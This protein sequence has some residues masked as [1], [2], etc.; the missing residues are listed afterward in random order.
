[1]DLNNVDTYSDS[2]DVLR[3]TGYFNSHS[4][5]SIR[6]IFLKKLVA[7]SCFDDLDL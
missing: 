4:N 5:T 7:F 1:M 6:N 3:P 2:Y